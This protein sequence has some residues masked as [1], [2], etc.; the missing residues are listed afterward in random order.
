MHATASSRDGPCKVLGEEHPHEAATPL[1]NI[2]AKQLYKVILESMIEFVVDNAHQSGR[3]APWMRV[4]DRSCTHSNRNERSLSAVIRNL[5]H[6]VCQ[7]AIRSGC[8]V[9]RTRL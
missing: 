5:T 4:C 1:N 8:R 3:W 2:A 9:L 6:H 7:H